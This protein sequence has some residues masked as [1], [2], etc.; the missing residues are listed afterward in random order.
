MVLDYWSTDLDIIRDIT[1][2]PSE[3]R[4]KKKK[5]RKKNPWLLAFGFWRSTIDSV[6][7][8]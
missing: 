5:K 7:L 6:S 1:V 8:R 3:I 4:A 2:I